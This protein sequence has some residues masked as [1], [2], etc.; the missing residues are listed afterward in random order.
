MPPAGTGPAP[1]AKPAAPGSVAVATPP[2]AGGAGSAEGRIEG[3]PPP[4]EDTSGPS[5]LTVTGACAFQHQGTFACEASADDFYISASRK[6]ARGATLLVYINVEQYKGPG[7]YKDAQMYIGVQDK[8]SIQRWSSDTVDITVGPGEEF[9]VLPSTRL[10]AEPVLVGCTG[11][12]TNFQCGGRDTTFEAPPAV[13]SGT[14]RCE[15]GGA[16]KK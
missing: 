11:P 12:M 15:A 13:A 1:A 8:T 9:A 6:A 16:K 4:P 2:S 3:C 10:Q 7:A 14:L 5:T